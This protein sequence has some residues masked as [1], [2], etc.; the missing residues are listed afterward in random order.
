MTAYA[1]Y[2]ALGVKTSVALGYARARAHMS[3]SEAG[4]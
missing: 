1:Y 2:K 4:D 3:K